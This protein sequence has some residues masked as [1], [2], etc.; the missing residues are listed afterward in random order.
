MLDKN[1]PVIFFS[2]IFFSFRCDTF[3][4]GVL[5]HHRGKMPRLRGTLSQSFLTLKR[6]TVT[7]LYVSPGRRSVEGNS[8]WLGESG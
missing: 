2:Y 5:P 6:N 3:S 1:M 8:G 4:S 7:S